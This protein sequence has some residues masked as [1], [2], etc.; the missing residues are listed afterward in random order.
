MI[1]LFHVSK[2][3]EGSPGALQDVSVSVKK[4]EFVCLTGSSGAGKTTFFKLLTGE[5]QPSS[6]QVQVQGRILNSLKASDFPYLRRRIGCVFQDFKLI[7]QKSVFDNVALPLRIVGLSG[8]QVNR[9]VL[10]LLQALGLDHRAESRPMDLSRGEQQ[11][12]VV[13]RALVS[14]PALLL[15]DEPT[16][17]LDRELEQRVLKLFQEIHLQGATVLVAAHSGEVFRHLGGREIA[18]QQ[19]KVVGDAQV[20][21]A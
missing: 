17:H 1:H 14:R 10:A 15:A 16:V 12:V 5:E 6:G 19:G 11:R 3:Y 8:R 9:R 7:F 18:L 2:N 13:A 20:A 4:G 21:L